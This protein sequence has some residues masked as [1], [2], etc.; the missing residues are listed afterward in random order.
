MARHVYLL[1]T[2][3]L[4]AALLAPERLP[5]DV[6]AGVA[7]AANTVYFSAASIWEIAIKRSLN[8]TDF[9]FSPKDIHRLA[10]DTGFTE[11]P[12]KGEDCY[13]LVDLPWRHRDPFDRL[14][15]AQ[16]QSLPAYLLTTDGTL[17]RY[18]ELVV[19]L[20]LKP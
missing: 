4:L 19:H 7:D 1:D 15:I 11:L 14:L 5:Q 12:V 13:P 3:V 18:S 2:N 10:L 17:S 9:D 6:V 8:R 20:V 16:A